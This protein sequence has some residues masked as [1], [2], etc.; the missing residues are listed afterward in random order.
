V[1]GV[2]VGVVLLALVLAVVGA[3]MVRRRRE[4]RGAIPVGFVVQNEAFGMPN[5]QAAYHVNTDDRARTGSV[6]VTTAANQVGFIVP[7]VEQA[8]GEYM[9]AVARNQDYT[10]A[11]SMQPPADYAEINESDNAATIGGA[12]GG[13]GKWKA[14]P[15]RNVDPNGYVVDASSAPDEPDGGGKGTG[16]SG[17]NVDPNGYVVD[18]SGG[19]DVSAGCA[20]GAGDDGNSAARSVE[21]SFYVEGSTGGGATTAGEY[22][23]PAEYGEG[24]YAGAVEDTAPIAPVNT[25]GEAV[26]GDDPYGAADPSHSIA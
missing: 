17:L 23:T 13:G 19:L 10:Y 8:P 22:G 15:G 6:V 16:K 25:D 11:P 12:G 20:G 26:Y 5:Q 18:G 2:T 24:V 4:Y 14:T 1:V 9:E 3:L 21:Y 7:M